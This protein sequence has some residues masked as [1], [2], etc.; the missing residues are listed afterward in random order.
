MSGMRAQVSLN[1]LAI[2]P[3]FIPG[4]NRTAWVRKQFEQ[5][6]HPVARCFATANSAPD[7][8][9]S[10]DWHTNLDASGKLERGRAS[11]KEYLVH[12]DQ[13]SACKEPMAQA[14]L[15][16]VTAAAPRI[17]GPFCRLGAVTLGFQSIRHR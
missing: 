13:W 11:C 12:T 16:C 15:D 1:H 9:L 17:P 8:K 6:A 5:N 10:F 4:E 7:T 3:I 14:L 2:D